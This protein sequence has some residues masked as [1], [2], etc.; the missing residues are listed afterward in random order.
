MSKIQ[1]EFGAWTDAFGASDLN[2]LANL[3]EAHSSLSAPQIDNETAPWLW[4]EFE[5][6]GG[7]ITPTTGGNIVG[8]LRP[9]GSDGSTYISGAAGSGA[10]ITQILNVPHAVML[11]RPTA[12]G[13]LVRSG[14]VGIP[15][16]FYAVG[17]QNRAGANL[18]A[19][20][21]MLRYRLVREVIV[22]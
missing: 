18:A 19:S 14:L 21:N 10:G 6:V 3:N 16:G 12:A 15:P 13:I 4:I 20:G 2:S 11:L 5:F 17:L 22:A 9:R 7:S 1:Y 8:F